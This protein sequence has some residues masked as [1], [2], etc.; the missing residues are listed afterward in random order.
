MVREKLVSYSVNWIARSPPSLLPTAHR[1]VC[2]SRPVNGVQLVD[3]YSALLFGTD[4]WDTRIS[5][6]KVFEMPTRIRSF[7]RT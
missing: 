3:R 4:L 2:R 6:V 1:V 5:F 7:T